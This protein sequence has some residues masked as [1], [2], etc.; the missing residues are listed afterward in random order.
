MIQKY[1]KGCF[2]FAA[3]SLFCRTDL[4]MDKLG[5]DKLT[6]KMKDMIEYL[7]I[8]GDADYIN[9]VLKTYKKYC[10][11]SERD[12]YLQSAVEDV[13]MLSSCYCKSIFKTGI[14]GYVSDILFVQ[15]PDFND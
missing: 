14:N 7:S 5:L 8:G 4:G 1:K 9:T 11:D 12:Q 13:D 15:T 10:V 6:V 3:S 2:D